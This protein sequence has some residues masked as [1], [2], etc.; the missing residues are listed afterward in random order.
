MYIDLRDLDK[1]IKW[2]HLYKHPVI[3]ENSF[4]GFELETQ[5]HANDVNLYIHVNSV[6]S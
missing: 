4:S 3:I 1:V 6:Q 5:K 2:F